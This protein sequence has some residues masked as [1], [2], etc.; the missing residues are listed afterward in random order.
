MKGPF[1]GFRN[2]D[3]RFTFV[4]GSVWR[5]QEPKYLYFYANMPR[6]RVVYDNGRYVLEVDGT[7]ET[8]EVTEELV[9]PQPMRRT[10][11]T[12]RTA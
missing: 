10:R 3:T 12:I 1:R 5:Q 9:P 7:D 4:D 6:A 8:V 2:L 11:R